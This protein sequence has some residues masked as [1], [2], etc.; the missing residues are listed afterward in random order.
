M[1]WDGIDLGK[2]RGHANTMGRVTREGKGWA[3]EG[4]GG[5]IGKGGGCQRGV[6]GE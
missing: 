2:R 1:G 3:R 4:K 6:K 5:I